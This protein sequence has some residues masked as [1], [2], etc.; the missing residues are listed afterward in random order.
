MQ[1]PVLIEPLEGHGFRARLGEPFGFS[2]E[3]ATRNEAV[4]RLKELLNMRLSAGSSVT[5][6]EVPV[7]LEN[8][9]SYFAG[10]LKDD[11]LLDHWKQA[12]A[13]YRRQVEED[14]DY[15]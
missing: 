13:D 15:L 3:G 2:A 5:P 10:T 1:I 11:P 8:T 4:D 12:M 6:L 14:P 7:S 9:L